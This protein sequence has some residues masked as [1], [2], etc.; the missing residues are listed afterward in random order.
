MVLKPL[1][2]KPLDTIA[3]YVEVPYVQTVG[4]AVNQTA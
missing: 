1:R 3:K 2:L 4:S